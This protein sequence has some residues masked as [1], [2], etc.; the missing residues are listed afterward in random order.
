MKLLTKEIKN[1]I[2]KLYSQEEK[3]DEAVVYVK[4]FAP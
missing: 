4:F 3:G 1:V 2:P